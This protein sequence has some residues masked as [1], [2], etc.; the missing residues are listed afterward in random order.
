LSQYDTLTG[1]V[2]VQVNLPNGTG[3]NKLIVTHGSSDVDGDGL[4]DTAELGLNSNPINSDTDGDGMGDGFEN[5]Y[6]GSPTNGVASVDS[7]GDGQ[8]NLAEFT[9]GTNPN[10]AA[11][12][13]KCE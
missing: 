4:T 9:S 3:T 11:I 5:T 6:F 8:N 12:G 7:D 2:R 13:A 10:D 1:R